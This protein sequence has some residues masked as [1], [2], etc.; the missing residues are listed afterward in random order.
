V[1]RTR[2][3]LSGIDA[4]GFQW[5]DDDTPVRQLEHDRDIASNAPK[6]ARELP[7]HAVEDV[8]AKARAGGDL[9]EGAE[10]RPQDDALV[11][12][13]WP[14]RQNL[15]ERGARPGNDEALRVFELLRRGAESRRR[16]LS[17][18][19]DTDEA[20]A[21]GGDGSSPRITENREGPHVRVMSARREDRAADLFAMY[22]APWLFTCVT[23]IA[24]SHRCT[25]ASSSPLWRP[26]TRPRWN[27]TV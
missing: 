13:W 24:R 1:A 9:A 14:E 26:P 20:C 3:A 7:G 21:S 5:N 2:P 11:L 16:M 4:N 27:S 17:H 6:I 8:P 25:V 18:G 15:V 12:G 23:M 19:P 10:A 22:M